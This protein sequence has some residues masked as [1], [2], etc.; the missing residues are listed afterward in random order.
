MLI[1]VRIISMMIKTEINVFVFW[2]KKYLY[3][4]FNHINF[5]NASSNRIKFS[6]NATNSS[7]IPSDLQ[8]CQVRKEHEN[9]HGVTCVRGVGFHA[10]P[11]GAP[12]KID[13]CR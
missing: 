9:F 2:D 5:D 1:T 4:M 12:K 6:Q 10:S 13:M 3:S 11:E 8:Q 7:P